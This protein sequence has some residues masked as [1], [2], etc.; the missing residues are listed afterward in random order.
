MEA[1]N[2]VKRKIPVKVAIIALIVL[3]IILVIVFSKAGGG[4]KQFAFEAQQ[5]KIKA[6]IYG[7]E[8]EDEAK[9][10]YSRLNTLVQE[11]QNGLTYNQIK[12]INKNYVLIK[13]KAA[14]ASN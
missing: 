7:V 3:V 10:L 2:S 6:E 4:S 12:Q 5:G 11:G 8:S 9:F 13:A 1:I 14:E